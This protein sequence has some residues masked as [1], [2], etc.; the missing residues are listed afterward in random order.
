MTEALDAPDPL[1][2]VEEALAAAGDA[3]VGEPVDDALLDE[4]QAAR[5][6]ETLATA[7]MVKARGR[8]RFEQFDREVPH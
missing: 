4:L 5:K 3:V 1:V 7:A 8:L 6:T 2:G